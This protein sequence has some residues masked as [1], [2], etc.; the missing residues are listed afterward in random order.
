M[1]CLT[2]L[3]SIAR[4]FTPLAVSSGCQYLC[5]V[6]VLK[7]GLVVKEVRIRRLSHACPLVLSSLFSIV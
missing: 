4:S 5:T 3:T 7:E 1:S 2:H 6:L